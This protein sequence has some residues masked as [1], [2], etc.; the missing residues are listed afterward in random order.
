[1]AQNI[2]VRAWIYE[3]VQTEAQKYMRT[4]CWEKID[5]AVLQRYDV[6]DEYVYIINVNGIVKETDKAICFDCNY[7][8][9]KGYTVNFTVYHGHKVWIP[10]SAILRMS[11]IKKE[12]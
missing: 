11:E 4:I 2:T 6:D 10:K 1:M 9:T 5:N 3:K 8:S 7:W 12:A